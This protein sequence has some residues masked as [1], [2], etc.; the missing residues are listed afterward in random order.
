MNR[1]TFEHVIAMHELIARKTGGDC[2][3]RD[4]ALLESAC[5]SVYQT[6]D[7]EELYPSTEE[8]AARLCYAL[9]SDHAFV[10]GNKRIGMLA[11]LT[12]LAL[13]GISVDFSSADVYEIG[14]QLASGEMTYEELLSR[15][16][17]CK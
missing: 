16:R 17:K 13:G 5:L 2:G 8:K 3:L 4:R 15:I 11:L 7:G 14:M 12:F 6:F 1:L 10:D 9:V